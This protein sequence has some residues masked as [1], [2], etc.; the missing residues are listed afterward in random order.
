MS[1]DGLQ[2]RLRVEGI[3]ESHI[4]DFDL[5]K[6]RCRDHKMLLH[7]RAYYTVNEIPPDPAKP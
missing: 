3:R 1:A 4:H 6:V 7:T 2:V 5:A